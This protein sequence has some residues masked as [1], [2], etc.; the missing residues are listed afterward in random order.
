M[1]TFLICFNIWMESCS[2]QIQRRTT[3]QLQIKSRAQLIC[4]LLFSNLI[5]LIHTIGQL[6]LIQLQLLIV[7]N[8]KLFWIDVKWGRESDIGGGGGG[9][10]ACCCCY[11]Y[12]C[13]DWQM[14]SG[15]L[16]QFRFTLKP[17]IC[18]ESIRTRRT[19]SKIN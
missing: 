19:T 13:W 7:W 16:I 6:F 4:A 1:C 3:A 12:C 14:N 5:T 8:E 18:L 17:I 2:T 15:Y 11:Y 10:G 9:G